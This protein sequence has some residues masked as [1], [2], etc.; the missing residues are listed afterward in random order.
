MSIHTDL[1]LYQQP[2]AVRQSALKIGPVPR[3]DVKLEPKEQIVSVSE[4]T[5]DES[6]SLS[7]NHAV[8]SI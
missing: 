3:V 8:E 1:K 5:Y 2:L 4:A 7:K 6:T